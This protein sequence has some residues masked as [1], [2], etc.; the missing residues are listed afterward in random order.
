MLQF[1]SFCNSRPATGHFQEMLQE[2]N[3]PEKK[4]KLKSVAPRYIEMHTCN[5]LD[6]YFV[7]NTI[8]YGQL[9]IIILQ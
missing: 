2:L 9:Y 3:G 7:V 1:F 6:Y 8:S 5:I 4:L